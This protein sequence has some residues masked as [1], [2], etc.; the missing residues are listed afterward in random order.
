MNIVFFGSANFSVPSL[1]ALLAGGHRISCVL[2]QP[3]R[4]KGRGLQ[5]AETAVKKMAKDAT[6]NIYQPPHVNTDE[7]IKFLKTLSPDLF[8]VVAYGQI[9]SQEILDIP[10]I[11]SINA[12]AS[13]LP[14]YRGAAPIN[15]AI[16]NGDNKT[17]ITIIKMI[18]KMDAGPI[19]SQETLDISEDDTSVTLEEKLSSLA[20]QFLL[21]A[22]KSIENKDYHLTA[23]DE[24]KVS[25]APKL[26]KEDGQINW[27]KSAQD[28]CNLIR[29]VLPWPGAFTYYN[30]KLLK[31]YRAEVIRLPG[32][33]VIRSP[34]QIIEISKEGIVVSVA[35]DNLIIEELQIEGKKRMDVKEFIAGHKICV[36]DILGTKK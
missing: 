34:A 19:I 35:Q 15:W 28:I 31:I 8:V 25:L 20:A 36:G 14:K 2:T 13:L 17:G 7:V 33:S 23:Q 1:K 11:F 30:G 5:I 29:G 27:N 16:I 6:L 12:H 9:L 26:K 22:I 3:D 32:H 4:Q 18:D 10:K 21:D 24:T